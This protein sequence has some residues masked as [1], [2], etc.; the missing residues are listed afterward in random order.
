[1]IKKFKNLFDKIVLRAEY[2]ADPYEKINV[3]KK[4]LK[5]KAGKN[6][7]V[8]GNIFFGSE[9]YLVTLGNDITITQNIAFHTHDG[10]V[11]IFRKEYPNINI[12]KRIK[13]GNN[14]FF[15]SNSAVM[16]G[17][18]IGDNVVI[19][20]NS[21]VTGNVESNSV[22]GGVPA[23]KIK[24]LEEYKKSAL[25]HAI[26]VDSKGEKRKQE[27][28]NQLEELERTNRL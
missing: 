1:M 21:V 23:R 26:F 7:R 14:V 5:F 19:A 24:T 15:G 28:L 20:A 10:G 8:T 27:I 12:F 13:V 18:T 9:P 16:P 17:A 25:K 3:Y 11:G 22:Y 2:L 6:I 4:R